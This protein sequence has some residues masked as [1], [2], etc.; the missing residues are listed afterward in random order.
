[1]QV[2]KHRVSCQSDSDLGEGVHLAGAC[3]GGLE[4]S[5]SSTSSSSESSDTGE[6][7]S[8]SSELSEETDS[9]NAG[10]ESFTT[11]PEWSQL[12]VRLMLGVQEVARRGGE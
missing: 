5:G 12:F 10:G 6:S 11:L 9:H 8:S 3:A 1:M 4:D 2:K 7:E